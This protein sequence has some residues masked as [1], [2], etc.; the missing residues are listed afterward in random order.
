MMEEGHEDGARPVGGQ[1]GQSYLQKITS[2]V[3]ACTTGRSRRDGDGKLSQNQ[4][5][6]WEGAL[7]PG[8]IAGRAVV[9]GRG[10]TV[11]DGGEA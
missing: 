3:C 1:L 5:F 6:L 9:D 8:Q 7:N 10:A 4:K 11:V 2:C